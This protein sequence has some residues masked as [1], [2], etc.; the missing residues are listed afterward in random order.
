MPR[1]AGKGGP[2]PL[3]IRNRLCVLAQPQVAS[4]TETVLKTLLRPDIWL[5][6]S[7]PQADP[8]G[9]YAWV[10]FRQAERLRPGSYQILDAKA[11]KLTGGPQ[12]PQ[13]PPGRS[14]YVWLV[15]TKQADV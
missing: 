2:V 13:P 4:T 1:C 12:T 11:R 9:D 15:E 3:F 10:L 8:S 7:T 14:P 5:G 6:T